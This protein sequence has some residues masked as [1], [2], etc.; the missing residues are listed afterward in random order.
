MCDTCSAIIIRSEGAGGFSGC[1]G[2]S[3]TGAGVSAGFARVR[4]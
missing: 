2:T 1:G 4:V 3:R